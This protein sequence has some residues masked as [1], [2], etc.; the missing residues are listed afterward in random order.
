[1]NLHLL[2]VVLNISFLSKNNSSNTD[3]GSSDHH[4]TM[5]TVS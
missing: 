5:Q 3:R 2:I 4:T 1:M